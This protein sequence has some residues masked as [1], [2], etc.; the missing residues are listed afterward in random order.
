VSIDNNDPNPLL[1]GRSLVNQ[2]NG[3]PGI[4]YLNARIPAYNWLDLSVAWKVAKELQIRAGINN[5]LDKDPPIITSEITPSGANNT[6]EA[7]DTLGR[8]LFVAFTARF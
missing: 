6:Y 1:H 8:Q 4:D 7:Y 2:V 5:V 3:G